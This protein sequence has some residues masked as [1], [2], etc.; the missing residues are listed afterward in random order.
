M[1]AHQSTQVHLS[2]AMSSV[3]AM[4]VARQLMLLAVWYGAEVGKEVKH[5]RGR[6]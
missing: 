6:F 3:N 5:D 1:R 4:V 2:S